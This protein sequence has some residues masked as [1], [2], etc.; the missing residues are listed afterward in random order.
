[1]TKQSKSQNTQKSIPAKKKP[2]PRRRRQEQVQVVTCPPLDEHF[3]AVRMVPSNNERKAASSKR[4]AAHSHEENT[5][6]G[7]SSQRV[8]DWNDTCREIKQFAS[9][10]FSKKTKRQYKQEEYQRL[11]GRR[12]MKQQHV[13]QYIVRGIKKKAKA[14]LEK[15]VEEAKLNGIVLVPTMN[16]KQTND[17]SKKRNYHSGPAPSIGYMKQGVYRVNNN[18]N[19]NERRR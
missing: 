17:K 11:T 19:N 9:A 16:Q 10:A 5:Q 7:T 4:A 15:Q 3:P 8:L 6:E 12:H 14:R 13:P 1:M 2:R 18:N